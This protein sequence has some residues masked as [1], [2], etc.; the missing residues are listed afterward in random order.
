M[1]DLTRKVSPTIKAP[2]VLFTY[3]NP[4]YQRGFEN[5]VE[6]I[7]SAGA[8]GLLVP[9]IPLEETAKLSEIC[10][11]NG[12]DLVLLS[13]PT[14]PVERMERIA[15]ASNGFIYLVSVTG[16]TGV[17]T[18]VES[19]VEELVAKLKKVTDKPVCVG[20]GI[21]KE[22]Q[23]QQ[24]VRWAPTASSWDPRSSRRSE[25]RL[26]RRR[27]SRG[28]LRSPRNSGPGPT[29]AAPGA[30][31]GSSPS[32]SAVSDAREGR[33]SERMWSARARCE[34]CTTCTN[35]SERYVNQLT[36]SARAADA[37]RLCIRGV[38]GLNARGHSMVA[39]ARG[40]SSDVRRAWRRAKSAAS[41]AMRRLGRTWGWSSS[42][43]SASPGSSTRV[44]VFGDGDEAGENASRA[45]TPRGARGGAS[46]RCARCH[47]SPDSPRA[48]RAART[49]RDA[50]GGA[51]PT[52]RRADTHPTDVSRRRPRDASASASP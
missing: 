15:E 50:P 2:I 44:V 14:T 41:S 17:R 38:G 52:A 6:E 30:A 29:G 12:L 42:S 21:S 24:V 51:T 23:A 35:P 32:S 37:R 3:Y 20:F 22:E 49:R 13:T 48:R 18:G 16:V 40:A 7:A 43:S 1:I 10:T 45:G 4:I 46:R 28:W 26:P 8:K 9:D 11:A 47:A 27:G 33:E 34:G 36:V 5:F 25:R 31:V 39:P 19:R